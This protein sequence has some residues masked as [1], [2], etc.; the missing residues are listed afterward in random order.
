MVKFD[1]ENN[2]SKSN[3]SNSCGNN[4]DNSKN[5]Q[6]YSYNNV[7]NDDYKNN[8]NNKNKF[9]NSTIILYY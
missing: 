9:L 4:D 8:S 5:E 2:D 6:K 7:N 3:Y 1:C